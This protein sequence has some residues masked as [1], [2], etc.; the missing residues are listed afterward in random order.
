M[1][2]FTAKQ[3]QRKFKHAVDFGVTGSYNPQNVLAYQQALLA[4]LSTPTT[5]LIQGSYHQQPVMH[6]FN[7][8]ITLFLIWQAI[9]SVVG[10][11]APRRLGI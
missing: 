2:N 3:L 9:L 4:H 5:Y 8:I 11:L 1:Y 7:L 6:H 10:N